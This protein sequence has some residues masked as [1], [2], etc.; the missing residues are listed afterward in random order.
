MP[1]K[2]ALILLLFLVGCAQETHNESSFQPFQIDQAVEQESDRQD[3]GSVPPSSTG[4]CIP[5][6]EGNLVIRNKTG[7][8]LYLYERSEFLGCIWD[9]GLDF[10][11]RAEP[12]RTR[13]QLAVYQDRLENDPNQ[14]AVSRWEVGLAQS[15]APNERVVWIIDRLDGSGQGV[16]TLEYPESTES[17]GD[18]LYHASVRLN[19]LDDSGLIKDLR[20][21]TSFTRSVPFGGHRLFVSYFY[22]EPSWQ[23][24]A[25]VPI[26][27]HQVELDF[28]LSAP[29][30]QETTVQIPAYRG[31]YV[32][33]AGQ[34]NITNETD[35][36][37][38]VEANGERIWRQTVFMRL[39]E[40]AEFI[41]S[42]ADRTFTLPVDG[43][44]RTDDVQEPWM[45][46]II[47]QRTQAE[48]VVHPIFLNPDIEVNCVLTASEQLLCSPHR[49]VVFA[50]Q[51]NQLDDDCDGQVDEAPNPCGSCQASAPFFMPCSGAELNPDNTATCGDTQCETPYDCCTRLRRDNSGLGCGECLIGFEGDQCERCAPG[52]SEPQCRECMPRF[53]GSRCETDRCPEIP[54]EADEDQDCVPLHLDTCPQTR[55]DEDRDLDCIADSDDACP[56][57]PVDA[58]ADA[59]CIADDVDPCPNNPDIPRLADTDGDCTHDAVD[60]CP[61]EATIPGAID[62]DADC[63]PD[64]SDP[65]PTIPVSLDPDEDCLLAADD[66]CPNAHQDDDDD[67][68]CL[69]NDVD[70]CPSLHQ[71]LDP[72]DDCIPSDID[73]CPETNAA[74]DLDS[75]CVANDQDPCPRV[76]ASQ[77]LDNDCLANIAD[78]CP[79]VHRDSDTDNDCVRDIDD[80]C[81]SDPS[82]PRNPDMDGDCIADADDPCPNVRPE[83]D[84]DNDCIPNVTDPCPLVPQSQD[85]DADCIVDAEDP[86][87]YANQSTD[88]DGDCIEDSLDPCPDLAS[89]ED[90]DVDCIADQD[91]ACP[92]VHN[93]TMLSS[94]FEHTCGLRQDGRLECW[95]RVNTHP[96]GN[97]KLYTIGGGLCGL[98]IDGEVRCWSAV[99]HS[100]GAPPEGTFIAID[101]DGS[102]SCGIDNRGAIQCWS[103]TPGEGLPWI[104]GGVFAQRGFE[105]LWTSGYGGVT[106][107]DPFGGGYFWTAGF[108]WYDTGVDH[109]AIGGYNVFGVRTNGAPFSP[110]DERD[111]FDVSPQTVLSGFVCSGGS[112]EGRAGSVLQ[113]SAKTNTFCALKS[114]HRV[115]C[116][117]SSLDFSNDNSHLSPPDFRFD[118]ISVGGKHS[119]GIQT[120][121]CTT[122]WGRNNEGQLNPPGFADRD[123][124]GLSDGQDNCPDLWNPSQLDDDNDGQGNVCE[125]DRYEDNDSR[126]RA[127]RITLGLH[128]NLSVSRN[129]PDYYAISVCAGGRITVRSNQQCQCRDSEVSCLTL[130]LLGEDGRRASDGGDDG[131]WRCGEPH[132]G[133][134]ET[135]STWY[136]SVSTQ[137]DRAVENYE[138][139][140]EA[141]GCQLD[142]AIGH[143]PVNGMCLTVAEIGC[144]ELIS[145]LNGCN[146]EACIDQ[147]FDFADAVAVQGYHQA[148]ACIEANGCVDVNGEVVMSCAQAWCY[149]ALAACGF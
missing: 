139:Y 22:S 4:D 75:D 144:E 37:I 88:R 71:E 30:Q 118:A 56:A 142:C 129:D 45:I 38:R 8:R 131:V 14:S 124:D 66:P 89:T 36:G 19:A 24:G 113:I 43:D 34:L 117:G 149:Q 108:A 53:F 16:L 51:F 80:P 99:W 21:G 134:S 95:G 123:Q 115:A 1:K 44:D 39:S 7:Q 94:G 9:Q 54:L 74:Q 2:P 105:D 65:C 100:G 127:A 63:R 135:E 23:G 121:G 64:A 35:H 96:L 84:S 141:E 26:I 136:V 13:R 46:R 33:T 76:P 122:C 10:L 125:G 57:T 12:G 126:D 25:A 147:C 28:Q 138:L 132:S 27:G 59:D 85:Q 58:D 17:C 81:P 148:V 79:S 87:P 3:A 69:A 119:C 5:S 86:C 6:T 114:D 82:I 102:K 145:C 133:V 73:P 68:D 109:L 42:Q 83:V 67:N 62:T 15:N 31:S 116:W 101:A 110:R 128:T 60:I 40:G 72:D 47:N 20:P 97:E 103:S 32:G 146:T 130:A 120:N 48:T 49:P 52:F 104:H 92:G 11:M 77:D 143:Y 55:V 140:I 107:V 91:D 106:A 112:C 137:F 18:S 78:A 29:D 50:E 93:Y 70:P 98:T 61:E 41:S 90:A 111:D